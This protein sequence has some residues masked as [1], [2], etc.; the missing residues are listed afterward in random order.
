MVEVA[1]DLLS[2]DGIAQEEHQQ[3]LMYEARSV[4][5]EED[6]IR[7]L[8]TVMIIIRTMEMGEA[9]LAL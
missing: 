2:M 6:I 1:D 4:E 9:Q 7:M 5:M 3:L 8:H